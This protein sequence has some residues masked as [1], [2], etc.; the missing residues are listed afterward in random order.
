MHGPNHQKR[1]DTSKCYCGTQNPICRC[2]GRS[3]REFPRQ[4]ATFSLSCT[5]IKTAETHSQTRQKENL[6]TNLLAY[7]LNPR[8]AGSAV[9]KQNRSQWDVNQQPRIG[10]AGHLPLRSTSYQSSLHAIVIRL[11]RGAANAT[12]YPTIQRKCFQNFS[13]FI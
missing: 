6:Y 9:L 4:K 1:N 8:F 2:T 12:N 10:T 5:R 11:H 3:M 13:S 7:I